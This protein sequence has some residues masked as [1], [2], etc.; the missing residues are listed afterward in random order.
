MFCSYRCGR[1]CP[2]AFFLLLHTIR[3]FVRQF[4]HKIGSVRFNISLFFLPIQQ[5]VL[6]LPFIVTLLFR[7]IPQRRIY[8]LA[9]ILLIAQKSLNRCKYV[10]RNFN[11][12]DV[13][14]TF[15]KSII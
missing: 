5:Y 2:V 8:F 3:T 12:I 7:F 6:F 13:T 1:L 4:F 10:G 15:N 11:L 9:Q 14:Y